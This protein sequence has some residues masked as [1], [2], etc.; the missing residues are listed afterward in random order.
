M[1]I[2]RHQHILVFVTLGDEYIEKMF[3]IFCYI[4]YLFASKE[5]EVKK[6]LIITRT[7]TMDLFTYITKFACKHKFHLRMYI[8]DTILDNEITILCSLVDVFQLCKKN[9]QFAC[10]KQTNRGAKVAEYHFLSGL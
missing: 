3:N 1:C 10:L 5:L 2:T 6:D 7:T 8:F 9:L 4:F